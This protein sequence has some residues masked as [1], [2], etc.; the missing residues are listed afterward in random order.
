MYLAWTT[1]YLFIIISCFKQKS[2]GIPMVVLCFNV[3]WEFYFSF[4]VLGSDLFYFFVWGNRLWFVFD[5]I[6][7]YQ[8]FRYGRER[9]VIPFVK[10]YFYP[11]AIFTLIMM[12]IGIYTFSFYY[13]DL[14]G[15]SSS[16]TINLVMS[17]LF[18]FMLFYRYEDCNGLNYP[19]AWLKMI[20]TAAGS[21]F[22]YVWWPAQF[23]NG[24]LINHPGIPEPPTYSWM[25]FLYVGILLVDLV[26]VWQLGKRRKELGI[27]GWLA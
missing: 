17:I 11:I 23:E 25:H 5:V 24:E 9:Q 26:Y 3:I 13:N 8:F 18:I 19:A 12:A 20:G 7:V 4:N 21:V 27:R 22:L 6:I 1:A 16:M 15:A 14:Q 2:Y 10:K